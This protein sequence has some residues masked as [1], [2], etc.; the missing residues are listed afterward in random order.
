MASWKVMKKSALGGKKLAKPQGGAKAIPTDFALVD[1]EDGSFDCAGHDAAGFPVDIS[2]LATMTAASDN[3]AVLTV[4][5]PTGLHGVLHGV[6][7]GSANLAITITL[8]D[9]SSGPYSASIAVTVKAGAVSGFDVVFG[10]V[11]LR[12]P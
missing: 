8:N 12:T 4:D 3:T 11:T 9:G 10:P 1:N 6:A 2:S 7:P 5:P